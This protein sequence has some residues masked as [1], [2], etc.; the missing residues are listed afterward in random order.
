MFKG[1]QEQSFF[2]QTHGISCDDS[3]KF[4]IRTCEH[5]I[6]GQLRMGVRQAKNAPLQRL[7]CFDSTAWNRY[8]STIKSIEIKQKPLFLHC[9]HKELGSSS[10]K[11]IFHI[12][13]SVLHKFWLQSLFYCCWHY[14]RLLYLSTAL[15]DSR[16]HFSSIYPQSMHSKEF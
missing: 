11:D 1:S 12:P 4:N 2:L 7:E 13:A 3:K 6:L 15:D 8:Y 5:M 16:W 9:T 10:R 14:F